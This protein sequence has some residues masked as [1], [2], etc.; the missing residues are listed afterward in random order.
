MHVY[1][2]HTQ[3]RHM[4]MNLTKKEMEAITALSNYLSIL[5]HDG[6]YDDN[7]SYV[8][9]LSLLSKR[10]EEKEALNN[11]KKILLKVISEERPNLSKQ[12]RYDMAQA[13]LSK[14]ILTQRH[15]EITDTIKRERE[16]ESYNQER[17]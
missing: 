4:N 6:I 17:A 7:E 16:E 1:L 5:I 3:Y 10:I 14:H 8:K 11:K 2:K 13:L 15:K 9:T 12:E